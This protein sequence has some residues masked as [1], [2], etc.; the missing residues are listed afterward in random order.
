M[1]FLGTSWLLEGN[2]HAPPGFAGCPPSFAPSYIESDGP[3]HDAVIVAIEILHGQIKNS[4]RAIAVTST[5]A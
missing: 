3:R 1:M 2:H 5:Y 4:G